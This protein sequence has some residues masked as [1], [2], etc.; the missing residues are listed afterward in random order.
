MW[1]VHRHRQRGFTLVELLLAMAVLGIITAIAIPNY[2]QMIIDQRLRSA[3]S[4]LHSTLMLA[5]SEAIKRN[6]R[7][8]VEMAGGSWQ[9]GWAVMFNDETVRIQDFIANVGITP[10]PDT[11]D[12]LIFDR[13]GRVVNITP[14]EIF[15]ICSNPPSGGNERI[16]RIE[17]NGMA[18]VERGDTCPDS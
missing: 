2:Q 10:E 3:S 7:V 6:D 13:S 14:G 16:I 15:T 12:E 5:R 11:L 1:F 17:L 4:D 18:R 8:T 9:D